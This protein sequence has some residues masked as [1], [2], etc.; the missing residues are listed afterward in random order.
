MKEKPYKI[1]QLP[2]GWYID[3]ISFRL[4]DAT[5]I[6]DDDGTQ[7]VHIKVAFGDNGSGH[8]LK[9]NAVN[10]KDEILSPFE[11][12][13]DSLRDISNFCD[14]FVTML[15]KSQERAFNETND[16]WKSSCA[17]RPDGVE[18]SE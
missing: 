18:S 8:Y 16:I 4:V 12:D 2:Y 14:A 17:K 7:E 10:G 5:S 3:D 15:G 13:A 11:I 9:L 1:P 6:E